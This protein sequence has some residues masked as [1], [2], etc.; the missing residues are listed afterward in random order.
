MSSSASGQLPDP[1]G[2]DSVELGE[3]MRGGLH[4]TVGNF[5]EVVCLDDVAGFGCDAG[6]CVEGE[7]LDVGVAIVTGVVED[8]RQ[9]VSGTGYPIRSVECGQEALTERGLFSTAGAAVPGNRR[10]E[11]RS[12]SRDLSDTTQHAPEMDTCERRQ[13][14]IT[15]GLGLD[16]CEFQGGGARVVVTG[17]ALGPPETRQLVCLRLSKSQSLRC[18]C[19]AS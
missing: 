15:G 3:E 1:A 8:C 2:V 4:A 19:G 11:F 7:D 10:F 5:A 17:L 16:D 13:A 12:G 9:S 18:F 6:Q 14:Y